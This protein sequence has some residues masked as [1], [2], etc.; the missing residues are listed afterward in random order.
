M[1][2]VLLEN[3]RLPGGD[4]L[5][6]L[7]VRDG[8]IAAPGE[9]AKEVIDLAGSLLTPALV[10]PHIHLDAVL[11]V[12]EPR[13][14]ETGSL[15]EGIAIWAERVKTLSVEDV[16]N[17]ARTV[18]RWQLA[19]GVQHVRSHV[20]VCDPELRAVRGLVELRKEVGDQMDIQLVA[21]PQQGIMSFEGGADLMRRAVDLGVDVIGAIPHFEISR[22]YGEQSVKFAMGLA[23]DHGLRV[24]I[25]CDETDDD[26]S[27]FVEVMAAETIRLGLEGR[28]TASHTTAMHGYNNAYAYRVINNIKRARMH[29]VT[30]PLD[31]SVLQGRFD[32]YPIRRGHT[33]VKELL[34]AGVN[35]CIGHD[36]VMDPWYPLGYGDPL[37]AAFV[38]AH[39]G[40]M[41]G[42]T[43]LTTLIDMIT[44]N[45]AQ[46]LGVENYG[47]AVGNRADLVAFAA[48]SESDAIRLVAPRRLVLR[49][50]KVVARTEPAVTTIVW[51]G[52]EEVVDFLKPSGAGQSARPAELAEGR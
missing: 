22:E 6:R 16:M 51:N 7:G 29:M 26:H 11:T 9:E 37:Q 17:R 36:S 13:H 28:V 27:R 46:A 52:K 15:F 8:L 20:D 48:P 21:F 49:A 25:H 50:G 34:A 47:L 23:A 35:T 38:L 30:N 12:G 32:T 45:P 19:N 18:L 42:A 10:E 3:V 39:Y 4:A 44:G 31:N 24:D 33:R 41:S 1:L 2:D 14:N 5:I 43:E 40:Q